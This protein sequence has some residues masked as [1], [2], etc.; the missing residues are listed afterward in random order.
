MLNAKDNDLPP[1]LHYIRYAEELPIS[2]LTE[3]EDDEPN[4][5]REFLR[6]I[7]CMTRESSRRFLHAQYLQSDIAFK[8]VA[9]FLEFETGSLNQNAPIGSSDCYFI[10]FICGM[11]YPIPQH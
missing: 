3:H 11:I 2:T 7:I 10:Y 6:I 1:D 8:R 9:G 4:D 5:T